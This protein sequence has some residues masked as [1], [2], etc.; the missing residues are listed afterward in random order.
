L[1]GSGKSTFLQFVDFLVHLIEG[2][3]SK[4]LDNRNWK[5]NDLLG[6][7]AE[8]TFEFLV[9]FAS[10]SVEVIRWRGRFIITNLFCEEEKFDIK[11]QQLNIKHI[12]SNRDDNQS[13]STY[14]LSNVTENITFTYQGSILSTLNDPRFPKE[15]VKQLNKIKDLFSKTLSFDLL[16]PQHLRLPTKESHGSIGLWG[17]YLSTFFSRLDRKR[18]QIITSKLSTIF[19]TLR[20]IKVKKNF[21]GWRTL[22]IEE[23]F[24][25]NHLQTKSYHI[26]DGLLRLIAVMSQLETN[27]Q[28]LLFD[29]IENGIN[30]ELVGFLLKELIDAKQQIVVTTHSPLFMNYLEDDLA[31][32]SVKYFYKTDEGFARCIPFFEIP[33]IREKLEVMGPGEAFADTDLFGLAREIDRITASAK[34]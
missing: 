2:D 1:N 21:K 26:N 6:T 12:V 29:E 23:S 34:E 17:E 11:G 7:A 19:P 20:T 24:G 15:I 4:W 18:Q 25:S 33:S 9:E 22:E 14:S 31:K 28:F 5:S 10:E 27:H 16:T 30:P 32:E 3:V 8:K 13:P